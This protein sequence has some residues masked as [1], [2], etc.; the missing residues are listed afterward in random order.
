[1]DFDKLI[2]GIKVIKLY[3]WERPLLE[4]IFRERASEIRLFMKMGWSQVGAKV[5]NIGMIATS[6]IVTLLIYVHQGNELTSEVAFLT[7]SILFAMNSLLNYFSATGLRMLFLVLTTFRRITE[8]LLL[9]EVSQAP[10]VSS[11]FKGVRLVKAT[12]S[13]DSK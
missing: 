10:Q 4:A 3:A 6:F 11:E 8:V 12:F 5:L 9:E 7:V 1:M 13:W 2:E